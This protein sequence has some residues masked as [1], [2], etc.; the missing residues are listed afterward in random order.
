MDRCRSREEG[1]AVQRYFLTHLE[2][3]R[4]TLSK[5]DE[6]H[7][8]RVMRME[9]GDAVI[10]V[11]DSISYDGIVRYEEKTPY[12]ECQ[13][14]RD[15][16]P[17]LP[18]RIGIVSGLA[19]GKKP[20]WI[21][22]KGT[23]LG[24]HAFYATPMKRSVVK[25]DEKKRKKNI[26]RLETIAKEAAEQSHRLQVPAISALS[27]WQ[28]LEQI[29]KE[30]DHLFFAYEVEANK[31]GYQTIADQ[32]QNVYHGNSILFVFGPE[33]GIAEEEAEWL[34]ERDFQPVALGPRILRTET[35]PLYVL[36]AVSYEFERK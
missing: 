18:V 27:E 14:E 26:E 28:A 5:D 2:E 36:S 25:W 13:K 16:Q 15:E 35:A 1:A 33:G 9:E 20:E 3:M 23:E 19:K 22:Q 7:V 10:A 30:Y 24:M 34:R 17:E 32:F 21:V 6:K 11:Y 8:A 4:G 29:A 12:I 31:K